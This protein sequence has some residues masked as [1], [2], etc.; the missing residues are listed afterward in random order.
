MTE[1]SDFCFHYYW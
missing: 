1:V